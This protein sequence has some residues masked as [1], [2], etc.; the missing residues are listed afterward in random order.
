MKHR[1]MG[2]ILLAVVARGET[3][4]IALPPDMPQEPQAAATS[5]S[6]APISETVKDL[7]DPL[8]R[9]YDNRIVKVHLRVKADW[10]V[11]EFK[12]AENSGTVSFTIS[13][14]PLMTL[15]VVRSPLEAP[16]DAY[17]SKESL[18]PLYSKILTRRPGVL[19]KRPGTV[20]IGIQPDGRKDESHFSESGKSF[21]RVS[22][23]AP[24]E[25]WAAA[26]KIFEK[27][28]NELRWLP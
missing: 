13:R 26:E 6:P 5:S 15:A 20:I 24:E 12:E 3:P 2:L 8:W 27:I 16:L 28:E 7:A 4:S 18:A 9:F 17:L 1:W 21:Y 22:F 19:G 11:M 10:T 25:D 14:L 23:T